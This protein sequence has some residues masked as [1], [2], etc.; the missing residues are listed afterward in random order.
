M[1][2]NSKIIIFRDVVKVGKSTLLHVLAGL[3]L[4]DKGKV[5]KRRGAS[6]AIVSQE[7]P[8]SLSA[9]ETVFRAVL[10]LASMHTSSPAVSAAMKYADALRDV[11]ETAT[12]QDETRVQEALAV[13]SKA[14]AAMEIVED[15][16]NVDSYMR[17]VLTRLS[18]PLDKKVRALSGGQQRRLG[19]AGALVSKPQILLLDEP[20]YVLMPKPA[21]SFFVFKSI[22]F[23]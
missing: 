17:S 13:L 3:V 18:L 10:R 11:D 23:F 16:W 20:T 19:L 4:P 9:D 1:F 14:T 21:N 12:S 2:F 7:L 5:Q 22:L 15:A 8:T 6:L